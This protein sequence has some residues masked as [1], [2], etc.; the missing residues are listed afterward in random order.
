MFEHD[1]APGASQAEKAVAAAEHALKLADAEQQGYRNGFETAEREGH[2]VAER[3][4]AA[5][6]EQM[7]SAVERFSRSI[8]AAEQRIEAEAIELAVAIAKKL[9]P[10]LLQREP[11]GEIAAL[12]TECFRQLSTAPHVVVRVNDTLHETAKKELEEIARTRGFDG[13]LVVVAEPEIAFGDCKIEW[14]DGGVIRDMAEMEKTI[15]T[16]IARYLGARPTAVLP[17]LGEIA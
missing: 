15:G 7:A 16:T 6:F 5:A 4:T 12:A 3:R 11:F 1:F 10:E 17:E 8:V 9:V 14:A 2:S 13:R